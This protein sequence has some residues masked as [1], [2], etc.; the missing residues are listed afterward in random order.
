MPPLFC[1]IYPPNNKCLFWSI[2]FPLHF[3]QFFVMLGLWMCGAVIL[4]GFAIVP[5]YL[6]MT[7]VLLRVLSRFC[8]IRKFKSAKNEQVEILQKYQQQSKPQDDPSSMQVKLLSEVSERSDEE[9][10]RPLSNNQSEHQ[11]ALSDHRLDL[12]EDHDL[13]KAI[14]DSL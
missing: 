6:A 8:V 1:C 9:S 5:F 7:L 14:L 2:Y 11:R 4:M 13:N 10:A 12:V 3:I